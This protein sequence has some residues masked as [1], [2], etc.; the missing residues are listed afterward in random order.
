MILT[1]ILGDHGFD[2]FIGSFYRIALRGVDRRCL[3][4]NPMRFQ[5]V[6][7]GTRAELFSVIGYDQIRAAVSMDYILDEGRSYGFAGCPMQWRQL[8]P[9]CKA[10]LGYEQPGMAVD[11]S[12]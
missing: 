2:S 10:I 11:G 7:E 9:F 1:H 4:S 5:H 8:D 6:G 12:R 3:M